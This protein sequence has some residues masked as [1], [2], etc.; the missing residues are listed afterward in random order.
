M[1]GEA[2]D[3]DTLRA[4]IQADCA[5]ILNSP[6]VRQLHQTLGR[7]LESY[8]RLQVLA[9]ENQNSRVAPTAQIGPHRLDAFMGH[10][11]PVSPEATALAVE[12]CSLSQSTIEV[13]AE[14]GTEPDRK[15]GWA[16]S[17]SVGGDFHQPGR[18]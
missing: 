10:G 16:A 2:S 14:W 15:E 8:D 4:L 9:L 7:L 6:E 13:N 5:L 11:A 18:T 17:P 3:E 1:P 12:V